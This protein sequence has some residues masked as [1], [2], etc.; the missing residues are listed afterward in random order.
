MYVV[1]DAV[2]C[3]ESTQDVSEARTSNKIHGRWQL[4]VGGRPH[5][6]SASVAPPSSVMSGFVGCLSQLYVNDLKLQLAKA[7]DDLTGP[8]AGFRYCVKLNGMYDRQACYLEITRYESN[9]LDN[10]DDTYMEYSLSP[11]DDLVR[12]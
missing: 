6:L 1:Y 8:V 12:F 9:G 5:E 10:L 3:A 11:A 4:Y 2:Y 7:A